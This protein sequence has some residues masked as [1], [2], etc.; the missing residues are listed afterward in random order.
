MKRIEFLKRLVGIAGMGFYTLPQIQSMQTIY[1]MQSFVAGFRFYAGTELLPLMK[2]NDIIELK[3]EPENEHDSFA[4]ALYW[5]QEKI[6]FLPAAANQTIARLIDAQALSLLAKITHLRNDVQPWE[7][8][9]VAIYFVQPQH[10]P[11]PDYLNKI[12]KP[13]YK[14]YAKDKKQRLPS[15]YD[16]E[17][18]AIDI[19]KISDPH[20]RE[21]FEL[22]YKKYAIATAKGKYTRCPGN[23]I[24]MYMYNVCEIGWI[25]D[26][27]GKKY[28]E[29]GYFET[30][31][32]R[33]KI[34]TSGV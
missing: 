28:L 11:V 27:S 21:Y 5:Q 17:D 15:V 31:D 25:T 8:V 33:M 9:A 20:A 23:N 6:G 1:L 13:R 19:E 24:Y 30:L 14:T 16:Y 7:S 4:V 10:I 3:R 29:F 26:K 22:L 18:R 32:E 34:K 2:E 12:K